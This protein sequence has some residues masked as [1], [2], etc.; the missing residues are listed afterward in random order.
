MRNFLKNF[1]N[2]LLLQIQHVSDFKLSTCL[3][4]VKWKKCGKQWKYLLKKQPLN[5]NALVC[6][7][8]FSFVT[9][10]AQGNQQCYVI[11]LAHRTF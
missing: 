6:N 2:S 5:I 1:R 11:W 4:A 3:F 7:I 8:I 9:A 10:Q